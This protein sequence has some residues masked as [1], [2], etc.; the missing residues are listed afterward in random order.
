MIKQVNLYEDIMV[1]QESGQPLYIGSAL[2]E[3]DEK[4]DD[5]KKGVFQVFKEKIASLFKSKSNQVAE[6][7]HEMVKADPKKI[8]KPLAFIKWFGSKIMGLIKDWFNT[9]VKAFKIL[10][11]WIKTHVPG[12]NALANKVAKMLGKDIDKEST[13]AGEKITG[14]ELVGFGVVT[15]VLVGTVGYLV[16]K[17]KEK[18]G[19]MESTDFSIS[20]KPLALVESDGSISE[21]FTKKAPTIF[22]K[23]I[24]LLKNIKDAAMNFIVTVLGIMVGVGIFMLLAIVSRP[25]VCKILKYALLVDAAGI[26][27]QLSGLNK[28][29]YVSARVTLAM[30]DAL[31]NKGHTII[32]DACD[33]IEWD[34][35]AKRYRYK[36]GGSCESVSSFKQKILAQQAK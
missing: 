29:K 21:S 2:L 18:S 7:K 19:N 31:G 25:M 27:S 30:A 34:S 23:I 17:L 32:Y 36:E 3:D 6:A 8:S 22:G 14:K 20:T 35:K 33:C 26:S 1:L 11:N 15:F 16:K 28:A 5:V 13:I 9:I 24:D 4:G 10:W 12:V